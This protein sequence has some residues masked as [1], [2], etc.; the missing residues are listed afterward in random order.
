MKCRKDICR[1]SGAAHTILTSLC[2]ITMGLAF[3]VASNALA[4]TTS[5]DDEMEE[6]V[7]I[8]K[9]R[10]PSDLKNFAGSA[11]ILDLKDL[12]AQRTI[13]TDIGNMLM[14]TV[15]GLT[16]TGSFDAKGLGNSLRGSKPLVLIDGVPIGAPQRDGHLDFRAINSATLARIEVIRGA[17]ALYGAYGGGGI[18]NYV[19][20]KPEAGALHATMEAGMSMPFSNASSGFAPF[21][22]STLT[23]GSDTVDFIVAG[24]FEKTHGIFD[25]EGD[26]L[27][28]YGSGPPNMNLAEN[29][30]YNLFVKVG[31]NFG[32][33]QRL[34]L[35][36]FNYDRS[37]DTKYTHVDS[38]DVLG[39]EKTGSRP[40]TI[41]DI[42]T[43]P[44]GADPSVK[45]TINNIVYTKE[46]IFPQTSFR[47]Q[48]YHQE[49]NN[50]FRMAYELPLGTR[51]TTIWS[52]KDGMRLD[53]TTNLDWADI[54]WGVDWGNDET[55]QPVDVGICPHPDD[56]DTL[57]KYF[58]TAS[59]AYC[60]G[61]NQVDWWLAPLTTKNVAGFLQL[62]AP[63]FD[64]RLRLSGGVR[65]EEPKIDVT[66]YGPTIFEDD[67]AVQYDDI[68]CIAPFDPDPG[69]NPDVLDPNCF[70][71]G[72]LVDG[73]LKFDVTL[74]N[75][76]AVV[77]VTD[78]LQVF[79][80]FSQAFTI[81]GVG[82]F[83]RGVPTANM[84]P[85]SVDLS[86]IESDSIEFGI[87]FDFDSVT[88][89]VA[90]YEITSPNG[91]ELVSGPLSEEGYETR[92]LSQAKEKVTGFEA[93]I[94]ADITDKWRAGASFSHTEG[95]KDADEDGSY[96]TPLN[97]SRIGP[98]K[99]TLYAEYDVTPNWGARMQLLRSGSRDEFPGSTRRFEGRIDSFTVVDLSTDF[100]LGSGRAYIGVQNALNN[101]YFP[102]SSQAQNHR[103]RL[104]AGPGAMATVRYVVSF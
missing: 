104:L 16:V 24:T 34:E 94:D 87:R 15:P 89:S 83:L 14:M 33:Q 92:V 28:P 55:G 66:G 39:R 2:N 12:E 80:L 7:V 76:G 70:I 8:G 60:G 74:F 95:E 29:V 30:I 101:F 58:G 63:L 9:S 40:L 50:V 44:R 20:K 96:D 78:N 72:S 65:Y 100:K 52:K 68:N 57:H 82:G 4:Q 91:V 53:F 93:Q 99:L 47:G 19:T 86:P 61:D 13:S 84:P 25:A 48:V 67:P 64:E 81:A 26:L 45:N 32:S 77:N 10:L 79:G 1:K 23:G 22:N 51:Q 103:Q 71:L 6:I 90:F 54:F 36:F 27:P 21:V 42:T 46:E 88:G 98:D 62:D 17:S 35:S 73:T 5:Y 3:L 56:F 75:A 38:P 37:Q 41:A 31:Y 85:E 18:I 97:G 49:F 59:Q 69:I 43:T 102:S 11:T